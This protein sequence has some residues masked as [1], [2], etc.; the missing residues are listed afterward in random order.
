MGIR[1]W[2]G[3]LLGQNEGSGV[4]PTR[5]DL[6]EHERFESRLLLELPILTLS[7]PGQ[8][9]KS[10][11]S[12]S[13]GGFGLAL[14]DGALQ[15][16]LQEGHLHFL[17]EK[18]PVK[19]KPLYKIQDRIGCQFVHETAET[20]V[21]LRP[22]LE[23]LRRGA[24]MTLVDAQHMKESTRQAG[25]LYFRGEGPIDL[26]VNAASVQLTFRD[27]DQYW[28]V[29]WNKGHLHTLVAIDQVGVGARM[30]PTQ[31]LE[32]TALERALLILYGMPV[33]QIEEA[34]GIKP[35]LHALTQELGMQA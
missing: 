4:K 16:G 31:K 19:F 17:A 33:L 13:Y 20:L 12:V 30:A 22:L 14:K 21:F 8:G 34:K 10:V 3:Q 27:G 29:Q 24:T 35:F 1:G 5:A 18:V 2:I 15:E 11:I 23:F 9:K 26:V 32:R 28:G 25:S 6:R 7:V